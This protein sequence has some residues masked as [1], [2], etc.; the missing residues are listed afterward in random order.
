M[1]EHTN[2]LTDDPVTFFDQ[3]AFFETN[4]YLIIENAL[5][6]FNRVPILHR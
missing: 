3:V 2:T 1:S 6:V 5:E 4:G